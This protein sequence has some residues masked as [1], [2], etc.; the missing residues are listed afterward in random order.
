MPDEIRKNLLPPEPPAAENGFA[1]QPTAQER[2]ALEKMYHRAPEPP[3]P[4]SL[5]STVGMLRTKL[6]QNFVRLGDA[7]LLDL[8]DQEKE[9]KEYAALVRETDL[10][11]GTAELLHDRWTSARLEG[12]RAGGDN[13]RELA[14]QI[15]R[16]AEASR[17]AL[18]E[19]WGAKDAEDLVQRAK[20]FA[21]QH[22]KLNAILNTRGIGS[23]P[24]VVQAIVSHV[25]DINFR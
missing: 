12:A 17:I 22:P 3:D 21:T 19:T 9:R 7:G 14:T 6:N 11:L 1:D 20:K 5:Y 24:D 13:A 15:D 8:D 23:R 25:R 4:G 16:D 2:E 10:P 18:R